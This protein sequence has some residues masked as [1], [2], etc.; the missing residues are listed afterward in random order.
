MFKRHKCLYF[1]LKYFPAI[2]LLHGTHIMKAIED[3]GNKNAK[4]KK[5]ME[6]IGI[7]FSRHKTNQYL[8]SQQ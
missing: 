8:N 6:K 5:S 4:I 7:K 2:P 1:K 3:A